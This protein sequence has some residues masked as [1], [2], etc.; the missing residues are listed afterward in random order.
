MSTTSTGFTTSSIIKY[1]EKNSEIKELK[2]DEEIDA[3]FEKNKTDYIE[4]VEVPFKVGNYLD[5]RA[6]VINACPCGN[7]V[8]IEQDRHQQNEIA[9][10]QRELAS[11]IASGD[12]KKISELVDK[13]TNTTNKTNTANETKIEPEWD[14][15]VKE[16]AENGGNGSVEDALTYAMFPKVAPK[17]FKERA[18]GP[19]ESK[20]F[21][22]KQASENA[23]KGGSYTITVNGNTYNVTVQEGTAAAPVVQAAAP[24][25]AAPKAAPKAAPAADAAAAP[26]ASEGGLKCDSATCVF[27]GLCAKNCP[28]EAITVDRANKSWTV[29]ESKC[30]KCGTCVS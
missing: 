30:A 13:A 25:A 8:T 15:M 7:P 28:E 16:A 2:S 29:D 4:K 20:T 6:A 17:F 26:A 27:C 19:V 18:N 10:F 22:A 14:K 9:E 21:M 3:M 1:L 12:E 24:V 5:E 11:A 23:G